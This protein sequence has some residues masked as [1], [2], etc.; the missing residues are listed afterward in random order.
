MA[1]DF[2]P[3]GYE[4][5]LHL[6]DPAPSLYGLA[7]Y[8][9]RMVNSNA[10]NSDGASLGSVWEPVTGYHRLGHIL[11]VNGPVTNAP[12]T[13]TEI[14]VLP[15]SAVRETYETW[16]ARNFPP[17]SPDGDPDADP[18]ADGWRNLV[19]YA[20]GTDPN[21]QAGTP[22]LASLEGGRLVLTLTKPPGVKDVAYEVEGSP[23]LA[24]D[25]W[26]TAAVTVL[27]NSARVLRAR[28]DTSGTSGF[29]RLRVRPTLP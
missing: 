20:I 7:H 15:Y 10:V 6:P 1:P 18:D 4:L 22:V 24:P 19:E 12:L 29:L 16:R 17:N 13:G 27:T 26:S 21:S 3:G 8:S 25:N 2:P 5:L 23:S 9:I 28:L 14:P 11:I